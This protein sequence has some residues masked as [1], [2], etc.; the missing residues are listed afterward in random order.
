MNT[1]TQTNMKLSDKE[2]KAQDLI[3]DSTQKAMDLLSEHLSKFCRDTGAT[4]IPYVYID[5]RIRILMD[6][7]RKGIDYINESETK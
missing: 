7:L 4:S 6:G 1:N 2:Q 5:S 3:I